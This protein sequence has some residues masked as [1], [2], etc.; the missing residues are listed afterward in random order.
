MQIGFIGL[1]IMGKA[2]SLN[3]LKRDHKLVVN[4]HNIDKIESVVK[5]GAVFGT[6]ESIAEKCDVII[7]MLPNGSSVKEVVDK[8]YPYLH[9]GQTLIDMSSIN[10]VDAIEIAKKLETKKVDMLDAPVSGGEPKAID[11]SLS[12]MVGGKDEVFLKYEDLLH[13]LGSSVVLCGDIGAGNATKLANQIIVAQNIM[14]C[15]EAFT[16]VS[17]A[18]VDVEKAFN[19]I[20]GGLAGSSVMNAKMPMMI[21]G[22]YKPGFKISLHLKD[23]NNVIDCADSFGAFIPFTKQIKTILEELV[24]DN[25]G[26]LDHCGFIKYYEKITSSS[27]IK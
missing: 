20:K 24:N 27:I 14:A 9:E 10:P 15:A 26:E 19:A 5:E 2:M 18:G 12:I 17:K 4:D 3:L 13:A 6:Q 25:Y 23:L 11:G 8:L 1:G 16:F 22:N 7:T 21:E